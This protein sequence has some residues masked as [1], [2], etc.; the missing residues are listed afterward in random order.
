MTLWPWSGRRTTAEKLEDLERR[1]DW[2]EKQA[3]AGGPLLIALDR[4]SLAS[5]LSDS[6]YGAGP[7]SPRLRDALV[8]TLRHLG[9][10]LRYSE[11]GWTAE[12]IGQPAKHPKK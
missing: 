12:K 2:L 10:H 11:A 8:A 9:L 4:T 5:I 7:A 1:I 3:D 6:Y